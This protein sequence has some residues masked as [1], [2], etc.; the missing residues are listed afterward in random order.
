M[1]NSFSGDHRFL[2]NFWHFSL[3]GEQ[4]TVEHIYQAMKA[5]SNA[6][7]QAILDAPS[8]GEAKKLGRKCKI[9][10]DWEEIKLTVMREALAL[11]FAEG[12]TLALKLLST[13][14]Q[15]LVEGNTWGD[16]FWGVTEDLGGSNW[17]G[18]LLMARRA[19]LRGT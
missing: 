11:K 3:L 15:R 1:I 9:R 17:L 6:E 19:E 7:G 2:S 10:P 14:D 13:G 16:T 5:A 12:S 8:P 18:H 4:T